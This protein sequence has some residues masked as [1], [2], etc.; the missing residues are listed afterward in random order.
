MEG[1][2]FYACRDDDGVLYWRWPFI[3]L[4]FPPDKSYIVG[5]LNVTPD[6]FSDGA[7][8][9]SVESAVSRAMEMMREGA[10]VIDVG[11]QSTRPGF[12][13]VS[14]E[15]EEARVFPVL[16]A[17]REAQD[18]ASRQ[19][20]GDASRHTPAGP[21]APIPPALLSLDT[22]KPA[23]AEKALRLGLVDILNDVS[24]GHVSMA[25]AA[26]RYRAPLI[27]MHRPASAGRGSPASVAE[28]LL[29]IRQTYVDA[30]LSGE[31]IALDPG[32]GFGKTGEENLVLLR[33]CR[34]L[35]T[36]GSPLYIGA[37]RKRFIGTATGNPD[38][39]R[40]LGGSVAAALW[41]ATS[42]AAF[43]RVHDVKETV[44]ALAMTAALRSYGT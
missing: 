41:A 29:A 1:R 39:A 22:D 7:L 36:L 25:A 33:Q 34:R 23:L 18:R 40:R 15:E 21:Q 11:G 20:P 38:A 37:S 44:E 17:L 12:I 4:D 35:T 42:G 27:L 3:T 43:V 9:V 8:Y 31:T 5:I 2:G 24:G 26:A 10:S 32:L 19:A 16:A 30:G 6:S 14:L 13:P 28:D